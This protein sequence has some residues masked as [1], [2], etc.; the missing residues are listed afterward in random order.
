M[1]ILYIEP[2]TT[3]DVYEKDICSVLE[4]TLPA[5]HSGITIKQSLE[6]E[7]VQKVAVNI[8]LSNPVTGR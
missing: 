6:I 1:K 4:L 8:I 7:R 5:W 3:L 2:L